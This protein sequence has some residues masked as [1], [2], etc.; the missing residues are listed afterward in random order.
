MKNVAVIDSLQ[1]SNGGAGKQS[2][3]F[4]F[5]SAGFWITAQAWSQNAAQLEVFVYH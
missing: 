2:A 4:G 1:W 5:T 3:M